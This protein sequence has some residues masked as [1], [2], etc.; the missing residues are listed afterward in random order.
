MPA[1][2]S[3]ASEQ[4]NQ[5]NKPQAHS[6]AIKQDDDDVVEVVFD[7]KEDKP[8]SRANKQDEDNNDVFDELEANGK[9]QE[10]E[11]MFPS[12][13]LTLGE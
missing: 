4:M 8:Y 11:T 2:F 6:H 9:E 7:N 12:L 3:D 10:K 1:I 13:S 5:D